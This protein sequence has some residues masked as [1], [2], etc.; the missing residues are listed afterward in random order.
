[1]ETGSYSRLWVLAAQTQ[2]SKDRFI[3]PTG[4]SLKIDLPKAEAAATGGGDRTA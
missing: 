4:H 1:M 2:F 3:E